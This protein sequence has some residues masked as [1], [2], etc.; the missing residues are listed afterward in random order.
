MQQQHPQGE[1]VIVTIPPK[2][3]MRPRP[4][5]EPLPAQVA[6]YPPMRFMGSKS[7]L[8]SEIWAVASQFKF[9]TGEIARRKKSYDM[10]ADNFSDYSDMN[11]RC[12]R[13]SGVLQR[14]GRGLMIVPPSMF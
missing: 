13:I 11:M 5:P 9:D 4:L 7:K 14:K 10:I 8:L 1:D 12:L 6:C 3:T 2:Q